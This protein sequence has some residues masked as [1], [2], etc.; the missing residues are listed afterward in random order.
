MIEKNNIVKKIP[1]SALPPDLIKKVSEYIKLFS[2]S[3]LIFDNDRK[4]GTPC[5][6]TL[7]IMN[8]KYGII[9]ARH[10]W[11]TYRGKQG[12]KYHNSLGITI[13]PV[14]GNYFI[15]K[16][17]LD[18]YSPENDLSC[19]AYE[20]LMVPDIMFIEIPKIDVGIIEASSKI[21]YPIDISNV[22]EKLEQEI[23]EGYWVTC[24]SPEKLL[25]RDNMV[26]S[27]LLYRTELKRKLNYDKWDFIELKM[28]HDKLPY[29]LDGMSGGGIWNVKFKV[30]VDEEGSIVEI[31][32]KDFN[33]DVVL[34]GVNI[35]QTPRDEKHSTLIGHGPNSIYQHL[36]Q[37]VQ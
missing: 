9:T 36:H 11:E 14:G 7:A 12:L 19:F 5:M 37:M 27:H 20:N 22:Q 30:G 25:D 24:G 17:H 34:M 23:L 13:Y 33:N 29:M 6:G 15:K 2:V 32:I 26:I 1:L 18:I 16:E 3:L 28:Y 21:F 31:L 10:I 8:G 4:V 35:Y